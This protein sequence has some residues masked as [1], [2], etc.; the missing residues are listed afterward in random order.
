MVAKTKNFSELDFAL[1][2]K[3]LQSSKL[4][5]TSEL[6]VFNAAN[7]WISYKSEER[8]KHAKYIILTVRLPLLSDAALKYITN[9]TFTV[10]KVDECK[11]IMNG[12]LFKTK[13]ILNSLPKKSF[14]VRYCD[15][16]LFSF[17]VCKRKGSVKQLSG[18]NFENVGSTMSNII[19]SKDE[20]IVTG[21]FSKDEIY[22]VVSNCASN[23]VKV[24]KIIKSF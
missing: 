24:K 6:E 11:D 7:D 14:D 15:Q 5:I 20:N 22:I 1:V 16:H 19:I 18:K 23:A 17:L 12:I 10:S 3:I 9:E 4:H 2:K 13:N 8:I 21:V